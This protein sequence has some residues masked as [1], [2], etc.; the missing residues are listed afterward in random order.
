MSEKIIRYLLSEAK[1]IR[2]VCQK[3]NG[4]VEVPIDKLAT[5]ITQD[6]TCRFCNHEFTWADHPNANPLR[7]MAS[8]A[9][10]LRAIEGD[11]EI[12]FVFPGE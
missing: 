10:A 9:R 6:F 4:A 3:C 11:I 8:V 7:Q 12:Q 1:I 2:V 5:A